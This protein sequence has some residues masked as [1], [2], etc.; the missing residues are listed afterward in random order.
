MRNRLAIANKNGWRT[1]LDL[2]SLLGNSPSRRQITCLWLKLP[3][4]VFGKQDLA[5]WEWLLPTGKKRWPKELLMKYKEKCD[6]QYSEKLKCSDLLRNCSL[7]SGSCFNSK[8]LRNCLIFKTN[9]LVW[10]VGLDRGV[11][12]SPERRFSRKNVFN[13]I[14]SRFTVLNYFK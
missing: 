9:A 4:T 5:G 12:H 13:K 1:Y 10:G 8:W 11:W 6:E 7:L 2:S 14:N 3:A